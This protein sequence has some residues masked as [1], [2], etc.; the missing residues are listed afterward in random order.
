VN[1]Q[2][3]P[4]KA[5][6]NRQDC[7]FSADW[8]ELHLQNLS[9]WPARICETCHSSKYGKQQTSKSGFLRAGDSRDDPAFRLLLLG[10]G[11]S[12]A[13]LA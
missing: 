9:N 5:L 6:N 13:P 4:V 7:V 10:T 12:L 8:D 1:R 11:D 3:I 2:E